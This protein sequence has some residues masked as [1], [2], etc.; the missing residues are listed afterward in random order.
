MS[1]E[2]DDDVCDSM[3]IIKKRKGSK[4]KKCETCKVNYDE[5]EL[6]C[7]VTIFDVEFNFCCVSCLQN[8]EDYFKAMN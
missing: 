1:K 2:Y 7:K 5:K 6:N 8:Y 3:M 4:M